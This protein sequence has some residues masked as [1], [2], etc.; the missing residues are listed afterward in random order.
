MLQLTR[1][2]GGHELCSDPAKYVEQF[3]NE[4]MT[5]LEDDHSRSKHVLKEKMKQLYTIVLFLK[6]VEQY[7]DEAMMMLEDGQVSVIMDEQRRLNPKLESCPSKTIMQADLRWRE[8]V[9]Q[10]IINM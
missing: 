2:Q 3:F 6:N 5:M 4:A 1:K 8:H 9:M 7:F 10:M